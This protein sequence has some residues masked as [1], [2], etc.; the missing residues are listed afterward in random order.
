MDFLKRIAK[1]ID[2]KSLIS[3]SLTWVFCFLALKGIVPTDKFF[4]IYLVIIAFYF[5][6]QYEK[7][8]NE[9]EG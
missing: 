5:G 8:K 2:V 7:N 1:L 6:T 4:E 9:K 3:L